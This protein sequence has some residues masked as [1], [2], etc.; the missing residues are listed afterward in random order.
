MRTIEMHTYPG[1]K[2]HYMATL[3]KSKQRDFV[4]QIIIAADDNKEVMEENGIRVADR[5]QVLKEKYAEAVQAQGEQTDAMV[6]A[7]ESTRKCNEKLRSAYT[8]A[9]AMVGLL[10][11]VL[12]KNHPLIKELKRLKK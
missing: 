12:G 2:R 7:M 10:S 4:K 1:H 8:D 11:G 6:A 9:S 5:I 3:R